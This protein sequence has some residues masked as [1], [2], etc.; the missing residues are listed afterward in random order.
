MRRNLLILVIVIFVL[1]TFIS[2]CKQDEE[3]DIQRRE[4]IE[5]NIC[6]SE[7]T[8]IP[9]AP[10]FAGNNSEKTL[11]LLFEAEDASLEGLEKYTLAN[12]N[13]MQAKSGIGYVGTWDTEGSRLIFHVEVPVSGTYELEFL[14]AACD[15]ESYNTVIVNDRTF[16]EGL[17]T[18]STEFESSTMK[19]KLQKGANVITIVSG[20]GW[21]YMDCMHV[22]LSEDISPEMY[23]VEKTLTNKNASENT[24]RLMSYL[25]DQ[26]GEY[27]LSGQYN[28]DKGLGSPE[29][30]ELYKLTGKYPAIMGFDFVN[31]SPS[32]VEN[33]TESKQTEYAQQWH[34]MGGVVTFMWHWNAPKDLIDTEELPW[35]KGFYTEATTFDLDKALSGTDPLGYEFILRDIDVI[36]EQLKLLA[37]KDIPV[38]WRPLHEASGGYFWWGAYGSEN[39]KTLWKLMYDRLTNT[40]G[41]NNLIWIFNGQDPD[42]YPGDEYVDIIAE[43]VYTEPYDYESHYNRF[44]RALGYTDKNKMIGLAENGEIPDPDLMYEDNACWLFF[45]TWND[46]YIVD[47]KRK[48]ITDKYNEFDHFIEVYHHDRV[49]TLDELPDLDLYP[50]E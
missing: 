24:R 43:D 10:A 16:Y 17:H 2:G 5:T 50:L 1:V 39:Y 19:A 34:D 35:W 15:D 48:K 29:I 45:I 22:R 41:L 36:A 25:V 33:G 31:Y 12:N 46:E 26:Y 23:D 20:W 8:P 49:I 21:I 7:S 3:E 14:T 32:R 6:D 4:H 11:D 47:K 18:R 27:T 44:Y 13:G 37:N 28:N 9:Q 40:H 38:L 42:W 30:K